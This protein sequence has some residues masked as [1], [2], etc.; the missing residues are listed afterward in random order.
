MVLLGIPSTMVEGHLKGLNGYN[1]SRAFLAGN[2]EEAILITGFNKKVVQRNCLNC[3]SQ[4]VSET[5]NSNSGQAV[6]CIHCHANIGHE[7]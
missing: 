4:L 5:C 7:K 3:H 1:H 6:S 2:F